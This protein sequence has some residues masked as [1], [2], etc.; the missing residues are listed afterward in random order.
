METVDRE[1]LRGVFPVNESRSTNR[2]RAS[3]LVA[4]ER[5]NAA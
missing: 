1:V 3:T 5:R 2:G 4:I